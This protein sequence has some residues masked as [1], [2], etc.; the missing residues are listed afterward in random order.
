MEKAVGVFQ[1][2]KSEGLEE[3]LT[4]MGVPWMVRW[5]LRLAGNVK[6][7]RKYKVVQEGAGKHEP[8]H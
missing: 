1:H 5:V 4:T 8:N 6:Y 3:Y 7:T 2:E